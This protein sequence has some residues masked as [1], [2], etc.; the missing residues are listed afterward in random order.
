MKKIN[1]IPLAAEV[2]KYDTINNFITLR[3]SKKP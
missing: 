2:H 1:S 3:Y